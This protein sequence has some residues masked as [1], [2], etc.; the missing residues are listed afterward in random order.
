MK[1]PNV[2]SKTGLGFT[3][4]TQKSMGLSREAYRVLQRVDGQSSTADLL[5]QLDDMPEMAFMIVLNQLI[6]HR[7]IKAIAAKKDH[8]LTLPSDS[9]VRVVELDPEESVRAWAA[10]KRGAK[11]LEDT[12]Y[13]TNRVHPLLSAR[14]ASV[15]LVEDDPHVAQLVVLLLQAEGFTVTHVASGKAVVFTLRDLVPDLIILDVMLPDT[16][17]FKILAALRANLNYQST[18]VI[19]VTS[20]TAAADVMNGLRGG[21]DGYIFKPFKPDALLKSIRQVLKI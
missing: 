10:A 2:F 15:L 9:D 21:A 3:E 7:L 18:P 14:S 11:A 4:L 6:E 17:G 12:G 1:H 19:M 20:Q 5:L 16:T 13:F 8:D